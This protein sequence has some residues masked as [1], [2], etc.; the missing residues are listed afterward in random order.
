MRHAGE[1]PLARPGGDQNPLRVDGGGGRRL[2]VAARE[3]ELSADRRRPRWPR[4]GR[5]CSCATESG[6]RARACRRPRGCAAITRLKSKL[7]S[8][9]SIPCSLPAPLDHFHGLGGIEQRLGRDA[10]PVEAYAAGPV[11][12]DHA[13]PHLELAGANGRLV[14]AGSGSD[15]CQIVA[16]VRH[17]LLLSSVALKPAGWRD[18][19][20]SRL[21]FCAGSIPPP[22]SLLY[23][24]PGP[25]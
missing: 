10:S 12:L 21:H 8:P 14:A 4:T 15:D 2:T 6:R 19:P 11:A 5:Y 3:R 16:V 23:R 24:D 7:T 13:D 1:E 9:V 18:F 20:G 25:R 17:S 22:R